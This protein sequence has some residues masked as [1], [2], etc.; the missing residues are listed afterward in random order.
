L[1]RGI[2]KGVKTNGKVVSLRKAGNGLDPG[3]PHAAHLARLIAA[4]APHDGSLELRIPGLHANRFSRTNKE[5]VHALRLP[6]LCIAV[7]DTVT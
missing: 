3:E 5:C 6:S 2:L 7:K 4:Y 1:E